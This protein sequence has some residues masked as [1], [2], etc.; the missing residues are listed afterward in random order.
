M[1]VTVVTDIITFGRYPE[2]DRL[3]ITNRLMVLQ[4]SQRQQNMV[5]WMLVTNITVL[6]WRWASLLL[7]CVQLFRL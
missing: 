6:Q 7:L 4:V 1:R 5:A 2:V 3:Q